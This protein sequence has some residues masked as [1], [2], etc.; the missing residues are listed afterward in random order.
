MNAIGNPLNIAAYLK[1][2]FFSER[3]L[4]QKLIAGDLYYFITNILT[5][6]HCLLYMQF[7]GSF[8][9]SSS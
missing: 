8:I 2:I 7:F 9:F 3:K 6:K 1:F 4:R 5:S